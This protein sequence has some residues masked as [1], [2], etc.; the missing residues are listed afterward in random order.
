MS[1]DVTGYGKAYLIVDGD[2]KRHCDGLIKTAG[3]TL[4]RMRQAIQNAFP[5][6]TIKSPIER[7]GKGFVPV[8][9]YLSPNIEGRGRVN[10]LFQWAVSAQE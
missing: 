1:G 9:V 10:K 6:R 8:T 3:F 7:H 5:D 4:P 2:G